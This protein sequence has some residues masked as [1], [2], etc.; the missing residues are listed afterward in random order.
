MKDMTGP[1]IAVAVHTGMGWGKEESTILEQG[2]RSW[3]VGVEM[4]YIGV[5]FLW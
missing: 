5:G 1:G 2:T 4:S 3:D